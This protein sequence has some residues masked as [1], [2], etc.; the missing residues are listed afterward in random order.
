MRAVGIDIG[1]TTICGVVV[2][3]ETA[4]LLVARTIQNTAAMF[5]EKAYE[6][7]QDADQIFSICN[8]LLKELLSEYE[9]IQYIGITG[10]MH[11]ILYLDEKGEAVSPLYTWQDQRGNLFYNDEMTYADYLTEKSGILMATGFGL[12]THFYNHINKKIPFN[13]TTFCTIPDFVAM[14]FAGKKIPELH[15]S[16]AASLGLYDLRKD[17]FKKET[18]EDLGMD[19]K[20]LPSIMKEEKAIGYLN[21]SV[22]VFPALGDN[23]ASFLGSVSGGSN[24]LVN[25]GT[26][27][28]I[29]SE[30]KEIDE[31][32]RLEYRPYINGTYLVTGS[33]LCGGYAYAMMKR[34]LEKTVELLNIKDL[35]EEC[36]KNIYKDMN[37]A[38]E[39]VYGKGI[40]VSFD[41]RLNG[42]REDREITGS[43]CGIT[44]ETFQPE[45]FILGTLQGICDELYSYYKKFPEDVRISG[46]MI[47]SGNGIRMN[48]V[49]QKIFRDRFKMELEIPK[50]SEEAAYGAALFSG[51]IFVKHY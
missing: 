31:N 49:L 26:G 27:S 1:T 16:M 2:E 41:T 12:V 9:D 6:K 13:A 32:V 8:Q 7:L 35:N 40:G 34:F 39:K 42:T 50:Y 4:E 25:V 38:A 11:G 22:A 51:K 28:Q 5:S 18:I 15:R 33:S 19:L 21:D 3:V 10:Q 36:L 30:C 23:Q 45:Y 37:E 47:G 14:K 29:S 46:K 44:E 43:I 17:C 48:P 24:L 20:L